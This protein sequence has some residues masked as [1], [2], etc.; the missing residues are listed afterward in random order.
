MSCKWS[1]SALCVPSVIYPIGEVMVC[2]TAH[3]WS[4]DFLFSHLR[5]EGWGHGRHLRRSISRQNLDACP[6]TPRRQRI[7]CGLSR[8]FSVSPSST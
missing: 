7:D 3:A 4:D 6:G 5:D 2:L 8:F 1:I